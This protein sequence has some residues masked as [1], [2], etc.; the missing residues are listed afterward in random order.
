MSVVA[1]T[2]AFLMVANLP[3]MAAAAAPDRVSDTHTELV[4]ESLTADA[5]TASISIGVSDA[6]GSYADLAFWAAP[7]VQYQD[8]PTWVTTFGTASLS[9][10]G[11]S[12]T[13]TFDL[14]ELAVEVE[15]MAVP[16]GDAVGT[17]ALAATLTLVGEPE[18]FSDA[19]RNGNRRYS[20]EGTLQH[21]AVDGGVEL[22]DGIVFDDLS[23]CSASRNAMQWFATNPDAQVGTFGNRFLSCAWD[24]ESS[25]I[26]LYAL[27]GDGGYSEMWMVDATG[28]AYGF[29]ESATL[30]LS[31]FSADYLL[32]LYDEFGGASEI[33][34]SASASAELRG[35]ERFNDLV[36][37]G[38]TMSRAKGQHLLVNGALV[39]ETV[40]GPRTL[41]M[42]DASC[43]AQDIEHSF[44]NTSPNAGLG[45]SLANDT[46]DGAVELSAGDA[47]RIRTAGA[48]EYAEASC[49][50]ADPWYGEWE[51][52]LGRTVWYTVVGTGEP[53]TVD[54]AGSDFDTVLAVY[55][56]DGSGL[57]Q[58]ACVDDVLIDGGGTLQAAVTFATEAGT[59]Y[60]V[61]AGGYSG[62]FGTLRL[63]VD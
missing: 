57:A 39:I 11:A 23:G 20:F 7:A 14:A 8:P 19:G 36:R 5:G 45:P 26:G 31:Q 10:D 42:D 60:F 43:V 21:L 13:A 48:S 18:S 55:A 59:T 1:T 28:F 3:G 27:A 61:Q 63:S 6:Y 22:P 4:C 50:V 15:A 33:V 32:E 17:A 44:I 24:D 9:A 37:Y 56:S 62:A 52:P 34:G 41:V 54:T 53:V 47:V 16:I 2:A 38:T 12:L 30:T 51:T 49:V 35:G 46:P 58:V 40:S 25:S 29:T